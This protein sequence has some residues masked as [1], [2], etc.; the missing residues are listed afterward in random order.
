MVAE[1][2]LMAPPNILHSPGLIGRLAKN[3]IIARQGDSYLCIFSA[4]GHRDRHWTALAGYLW[5]G[6][7]MRVWRVCLKINADRY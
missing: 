7:T 1:L 2:D 4:L 6:E 3:T 5:S